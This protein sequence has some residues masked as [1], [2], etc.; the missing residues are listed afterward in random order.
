MMNE[1]PVRS[2]RSHPTRDPWLKQVCSLTLTVWPQYE[3][4]LD[5]CNCYLLD[6]DQTLA[7]YRLGAVYEVCFPPAASRSD[8]KEA[9]G[10]AGSLAQCLDQLVH[11]ALLSFMVDERGYSAAL[12]E[13]VFDSTFCLKGL[14]FDHGTGDVLKIDEDGYICMARH[15]YAAPFMPPAEIKARYPG[16]RWPRHEQMRRRERGAYFLFNTLFDVPVCIPAP[17]PGPRFRVLG[18]CAQALKSCAQW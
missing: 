12:K 15:G 9:L 4:Q 7:R 5:K 16:S 11:R 2:P 1:T 14:V 18:M 6:M 10:A 13:Q 3:V 17:C 8:E